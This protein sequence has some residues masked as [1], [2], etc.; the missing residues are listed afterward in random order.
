MKVGKGVDVPPAPCPVCGKKLDAASMIGGE[1]K[2]TP[3]C[4]TV[5]MYCSEILIFTAN[6]KLRK[7]NYRE[8]TNVQMSSIWP[9]LE[10]LRR[11]AREVMS[12]KINFTQ[13]CKPREEKEKEKPN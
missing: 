5:C 9:L 2:P 8:L 13:R 7:P 6:L 4:Y 3:G 11:A 10:K 1:G 12:D